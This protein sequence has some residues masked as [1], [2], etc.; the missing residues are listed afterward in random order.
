MTGRPFKKG[1][2]GNPGGRPRVAGELRALAS[3]HVPA[4]I[5]E[6]AR[7]A[8]KARSESVRVAAIP[9]LFD[10][11]Y[12]RAMPPSV[13]IEL[14][15]IG[16]WNGAAAIRGRSLCADSSTGTHRAS[17]RVLEPIPKRETSDA[18]KLAV[19]LPFVP[20]RRVPSKGQI[21]IEL[22]E[23]AAMQNTRTKIVHL[24]A[25]FPQSCTW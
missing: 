13:A 2:S 8:L 16:E 14:P 20:V 18:P 23:V 11:G 17:W 1:Q 25:A 12:G 5:E 7:L 24:G 3:Q 22:H 21:L 15:A 4:A 10:R 9:E 19:K 6:L